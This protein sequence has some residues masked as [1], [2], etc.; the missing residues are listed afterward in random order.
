MKD[1]KEVKELIDSSVGLNILLEKT[2]QA[3]VQTQKPEQIS[4][5]FHGVDASKSARYYPETNSMYCW[6]CKKSWTPIFYWME[7]QEIK[8]MAAARQ[9]ADMFE[10]DLSK[11]SEVKLARLESF[12]RAGKKEVDKKQMA[13]Y[14]LEERIKMVKDLEQPEMF[15]KMLYVFLSA[16]EIEDPKEFAKITLP[17]AKRLKATL[18][19]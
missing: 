12:D 8:F 9:L 11:L 2:G 19:N 10:I 14:L 16:R 17:L 18:E 1:P 13:L 7:Y 5:P 4:C 15:A 6:T 3:S